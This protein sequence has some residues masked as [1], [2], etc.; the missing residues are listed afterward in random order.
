MKKLGWILF[1][2]LA[3]VL[4]FSPVLV[5][6][7]VKT[8]CPPGQQPRFSYGFAFLKTQLGPIMGEPLECEHYDAEGNARQ[9]TTT[10]QAFYLQ[11]NNTPM[12]TAG[13]RHWAWTLAGL[14]QWTDNE[15]EEAPL[16]PSPQTLPLRVM[17]YNV[18]Y[19]AG[20]DPEWERAAAKLSPF[21]YPGNR[22]PQVLEVIK[23]TQPDILGVEEAAGWDKESP[24]RAQQIATELGMNYFLAPTS[25][26]LHVTLFTRFKIV[27]AENLSEQMGNVGALRA[28]LAAPAGQP[29]HVFVV[30]LDPFSTKTRTAELATMT[31]LMAPY[32]RLPTILLGDMN[33][34]CLDDLADCQEYQV[35]SGAGWR[36]AVAGSYQ[37]DQIW[38]SPPLDQPVEAIPFPNALFDRSDHLPVA[39]VLHLPPPSEGY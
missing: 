8:F 19:G 26:G 36:L 21:A 12:F 16:T 25:S 29:V 6:A 17:A 38:V 34:H 28:Q 11:K 27:E 4:F 32:Q 33:F 31:E 20:A 37:I 2:L 14:Q 10:G 7:Q 3:L 39:G 15:A 23:N 5:S 18:L 35:L 30:H 1:I 13:N 22:L 9:K 24:P